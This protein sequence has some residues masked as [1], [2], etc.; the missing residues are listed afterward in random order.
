MLNIKYV[1]RIK[2]SVKYR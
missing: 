1:Q 2:V